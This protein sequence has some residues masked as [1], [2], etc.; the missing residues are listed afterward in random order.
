VC[1]IAY[2]NQKNRGLAA[3]NR[4]TCSKKEISSLYISKVGMKNL[5]CRSFSCIDVLC[6]SEICSNKFIEEKTGDN[7]PSSLKLHLK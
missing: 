6:S 1:L 3:E 5:I 7:A 2:K 4:C